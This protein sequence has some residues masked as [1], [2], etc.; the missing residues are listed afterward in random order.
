MMSFLVKHGPIFNRI[1]LYVTDR[2]LEI[3]E[4]YEISTNPR[5]IIETKCEITSQMLSYIL[6]DDQKITMI[7]ANL[8]QMIK[9][10][11]NKNF[12]RLDIMGADANFPGISERN[13]DSA[14]LNTGHGACVLKWEGRYF[15]LQSYLGKYRLQSKEYSFQDLKIFLEIWL[16]AHEDN[17][18]KITQVE[19]GF[20]KAEVKYYS[21][22]LEIP[23][24]FTKIKS[25]ILIMLQECLNKLNQEEYTS[26]EYVDILLKNGVKENLVMEA[27]QEITNLI[28][29][30]LSIKT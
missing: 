13:P 3:D 27:K 24:D 19:L 4:V 25:R 10:I 1:F 9:E 15:V 14:L 6:L 11:E 5:K 16:K 12:L 8:E 7:K 30:F 20:V 28:K 21:S 2:F 26:D 18:K 22:T 23:L 17:W 29:K